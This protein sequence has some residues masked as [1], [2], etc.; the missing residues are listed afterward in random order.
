MA[1][2]TM[3]LFGGT[4][5]GE[6]GAA[7]VKLD[8]VRMEYAGAESLSWEELFD[9][10]D[11]IRAI[12]FSSG[13]GFVSKLLARFATAEIIFGCEDVMSGTLQDVMAYQ[14]MLIDRLRKNESKTERAL[15]GRIEAG[16]LKLFVARKQLSHEKIYLL[17]AADGRRRV[18]MGSAN[19]SYNAFGGRQREN[20]C[21][22]DGD[23]AY[24]WY[25]GC[26]E[27][28]KKSSVDEITRKALDIADAAEN[29]DALPISETV[30]VKKA[31]YIEP[32]KEL[33]EEVRF[34]LDTRNLS[35]QLAPS[36]P[37][38]VKPDKKTGRVLVVPDA[39]VKIRRQI[40]NERN[41]E[42]V[43][44]NEYPQLNVNVEER[45]VTLNGT[46]LDLRPSSEEVGGDIA[47]YLKYMDGYSRFHGEW[48]EM[49]NRYFEFTNWF[50]CSPFMAV[51]RDMASRYDQ[52]RLPYPVFGLLYGQSKA[53]KTTFLETLLKMMIGQKTKVSAPD[54]TRKAIAELKMV[55]QGAPIIVD[56]LTQ[57][58]FS[59]HAVETIKWDDFGVDAH[60]VN[61][62]AVV[63]SANEDVKA[64]AQEVTRR[65][66]ICR[67][68]AGLTNTE[69]MKSNVVRTVQQKM[70]T[71]FYREYLRRMLEVLPDLIGQLKDDET[72]EA[73]DILKVSSEILCA[74][75]AEHGETP[76]YVRKLS[77]DSYFSE[78]VTGKYAIKVIQTAW[79]TSRDSFQVSTRNNELRYNAGA[80][81]EVDR[82]VKELPE[83]LEPRKSRDWL[84]V[85]L[86]IAREFFGV[87]F[88]ST[89]W[90]RMR[91]R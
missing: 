90:D 18:V 1:D 86:D 63:I 37:A 75:V 72:E 84:I 13:V 19:M 22:V 15:I 25:L 57:T 27:D 21:Y 6:T 88:R 45:K 40:V 34:I 44:R 83:T 4:E 68:Q 31:I 49:Q 16:T 77:L 47:L 35:K 17:S 20:I 26:Y 62:P 52:N 2:E 76:P 14:S 67:V 11:D 91:G 60:N 70:G 51:M 10:F 48:Q 30:K 3:D 74:I 5:S 39:I 58:R 42:K 23:A 87:N 33:D 46:E 8:V 55:V 38:V 59:Q 61:Y 56:D 24:D 54:F 79:R 7:S 53:G 66:I 80:T 82:L 41:E 71:A 89:L 32:A 65:T 78:E 81:F 28:L 50:F 73:P 12:T 64:I 85:N 69:V 29:A 43:R 9:G 36:L